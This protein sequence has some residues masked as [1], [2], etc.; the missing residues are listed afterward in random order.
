M[1][2]PKSGT[3]GNRVEPAAPDASF[4]ADQADP[5]QVESVKAGQRETKTGKYGSVQ[6]K[7]F[8]GE[9]QD[10]AT[11]GT[12]DPAKKPSW[13]EIELVDDKGKPVA[14]EA[15]KITMPD[16]SVREGTLDGK[17]FARVGGCDPGTCKVTFPLLDGRSWK[18][19]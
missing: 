18:K 10:P 14:G 8:N 13:I 2:S 9:E 4:D 12:D 5:G 16:D 11:E 7:S 1:P 17:G 3:A 15:Y 19:E 6:V